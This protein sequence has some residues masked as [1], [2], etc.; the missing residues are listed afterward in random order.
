MRLR[1]AVPALVP[2]DKFADRLPGAPGVNENARLQLWPAASA[3]LTVQVPERE[4]S[5]GFAPPVDIEAMVSVR[6]RCSSR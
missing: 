5:P 3:V 6:C 1:F 2:T 4:N